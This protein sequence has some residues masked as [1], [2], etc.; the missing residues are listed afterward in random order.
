MMTRPKTSLLNGLPPRGLCRNVASQY[1]GISP[2]KF[3]QMVS[4]G[5]MPTAKRIDGRKV[6]DRDAI[7]AAFNA[8]PDDNPICEDNPWDADLS[9]GR[10]A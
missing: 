2:S 1:I 9:G 7:D 4:D 5:R 10:A 6:W 3:D 8:L